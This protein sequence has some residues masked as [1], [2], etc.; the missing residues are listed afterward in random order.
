MSALFGRSNAACVSNSLRGILKR[1]R[2]PSLGDRHFRG[3]NTR[4]PGVSRW[5]LSG[6]IHAGASALNGGDTAPLSSI[7]H[8][9]ASP[10]VEVRMCPAFVFSLPLSRKERRSSIATRGHSDKAWAAN[11]AAIL[12]D[13]LV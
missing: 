3:A 4:S 9:P 6:G 7:V 2:L 1:I 5:R 8:F 10:T 12:N 11:C 13:E